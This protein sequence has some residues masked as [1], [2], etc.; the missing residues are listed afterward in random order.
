MSARRLTRRE[1]QRLRTVAWHEAGHACVAVEL[2][3]AF[4]TVDIIGNDFGSAGAVRRSMPL[5]KFATGMAYRSTPLPKG[6]ANVRVVNWIEQRILLEFA[7]GIAQRRYAPRSDWAY[8]M[9]HDGIKRQDLHYDDVITTYRVKTAYRSGLY[10]INEWLKR[11][12]R[13][14][15][16]T[17]RAKLEAR[18]KVLVR[19]LWP[20]IQRVAKV[21]LKKKVL[22]QAQV[23]RLMIRARR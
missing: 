10:H 12:G 3:D 19:E 16:E 20:D 2:K 23:R 13:Y 18:S 1:M 22:T 17:Y 7:V 14:G 11:L 21:L 5:P 4:T 9:G 8:G 6:R 15:D